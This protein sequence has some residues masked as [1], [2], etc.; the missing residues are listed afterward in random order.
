MRAWIIAIGLV[1]L[2]LVVRVALGGVGALDR[3]RS[4]DEVGDTVVAVMEYRQALSWYLPIAPWR[5]DAADGLMRL[6]QASLDAGRWEEAVLRLN[7]L[8]SGFLGGRSLLGVDDDA[9][10]AVDV[11]LSRALAQWEAEAAIAEQRPSAGSVAERTT[12]YAGVLANDPMPSRAW[13]LVAVLGFFLW[14]GGAWW[15]AGAARTPG[16]ACTRA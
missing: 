4:A 2:G 16:D 7:M 6:S 5:G 10:S 13:G 12:H 15:A 3:A 8:R 1:M 9:L 14:L 11:L